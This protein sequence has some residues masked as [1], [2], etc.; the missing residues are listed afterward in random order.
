MGATAKPRRFGGDD[1]GGK[2]DTGVERGIEE[3]V[4]M[5]VGER[6][7]TP[8]M[9]LTLP[10]VVGAKDQE[11]W[12]AGNPGLGQASRRQQLVD[13][14]PQLPVLDDD[15]VALLQVALARRGK[16]KRA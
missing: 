3:D 7:A 6:L 5:I 10:A 16:G 1:E 2:R 15:D 11:G 4:Q 9:Q 13:G 14:L 12:G 8:G